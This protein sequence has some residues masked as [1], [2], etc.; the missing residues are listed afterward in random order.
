MEGFDEVI[1][2][3]L[4]ESYESLDQLDRDLLAL[5]DTPGDRDRLSS[6]FRTIHTIKG[7]SGF[8]AFP[9]LERV[10]HV[11]ESLLVPLRDGDFDLTHNMADSLLQ[12]VDAIRDILGSIESNGKEGDNEYKALVDRLEV[13]RKGD[14]DQASASGTLNETTEPSED[15]PQPLEAAKNETK[16][17]A[18]TSETPATSN[19]PIATKPPAAAKPPAPASSPA[20]NDAANTSEQAERSSSVADSTVRINVELLDKLMNLVGELVLSRN[21]IVQFSET[22]DDMTMI[23]ASQRLNLITSE[24]QEGVMKT[25]MQ[26]IRNAWNKLPR[27][28]R[29]LS[30]SCGKQ[31]VVRMEG[32]DTELDKT[33]LEALK[34][35]L[36]H[37]V[38]NSVDHGIESAEE[39]EK[40]GKPSEGTLSLR[41]FHEG[42]QVNIEICDDGAGI[43][44]TRVR[45]KAIEKQLI[46]AEQADR[47]SERE[48]T[49]LILL[50]GF[51]TAAAVTNV[52][53][54]G[55]GMDV[56]KTN[57]ERIGGTV[58]IQ[59]VLGEGTTLKIKIPLT[60]AIVPA[61]IVKSGDDRFAIPQVNLL[62]LLRLDGDRAT[63]QIEYIHDTPVYRLRGNLLPLIYLDEQIGLHP[64]RSRDEQPS[65]INIVVLKAEEQHFGLVVDGITDTQEIVVKP[66]GH[67][68]KAISTYAGAT[69]MGDGMIALILDV[70]GLARKSSVLSETAEQAP[71]LSDN[72]Q[73]NGLGV[74][75]SLLIF[76]P[77][78]ET[79]AAV[80]LS[81]VARLEEFD[82]ADVEKSGNS[83]VVQY[84][85][86]IL[87]LVYL[88]GQP[89]WMPG[90]EN[91]RLNTIVFSQG[92]H[93]VGIVVGKILDIVHERLD[94]DGNKPA[95]RSIIQNRV[96]EI[97]DLADFVSTYHPEFLSCPS[98]A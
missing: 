18:D 68:M 40:C 13:L 97:V 84:R 78:D 63:D 42:G 76:D 44:P 98:M 77:G 67:H 88:S 95:A 5:E 26:P 24:L 70:V 85:D 27:V 74:K 11:G 14:A 49:N 89:Q 8:L 51:S 10:A 32:A 54:R 22:S 52:S 72:E 45:E 38:R 16:S 29:D 59:S 12:M 17:S 53:G 79:R 66:L 15:T 39:R 33:I 23:A 6:I 92:D 75:Q 94:F 4:V 28:V 46:T 80:Q 81:A 35:P 20:T 48:L 56:V 65:P 91:V 9:K 73:T 41:A 7:T 47:M 50:P 30:A 62:E 82:S 86:N 83:D 57:I 61:L 37:I 71:K 87:P 60:L 58:D 43:N 31:V 25:R 69:I 19:P 64:A 93:S 90:E 21:Q 55:V 2:E 1:E 3:F 34:D 36:T 96:T